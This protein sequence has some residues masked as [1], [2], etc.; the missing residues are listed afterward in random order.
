[1][2]RN[3]WADEPG[4]KSACYAEFLEADWKKMLKELND[5]E[6]AEELTRMLEM[7]E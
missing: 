7:P 2:V 3:R 4:K 5:D 1:M 6:I